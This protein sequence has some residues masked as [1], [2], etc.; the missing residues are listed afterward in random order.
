MK[1]LLEVFFPATSSPLPCP[2]AF[3]SLSVPHGARGPVCGTPHCCVSV[4]C[5]YI[6]VISQADILPKKKAGVGRRVKVCCQNL[7]LLN[8]GTPWS[9]AHLRRHYVLLLPLWN[10]NHSSQF[11]SLN[12]NAVPHIVYGIPQQ[13]ILICPFKSH[14]RKDAN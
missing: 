3:I 10:F 5:L 6:S 14:F 9:C 2:P 12:I 8:F 7:P 13:A 1:S 4:S 11:F